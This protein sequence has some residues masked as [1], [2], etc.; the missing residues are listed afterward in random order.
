MPVGDCV[1]L[2][3]SVYSCVCVCMLTTCMPPESLPTFTTTH[4]HCH[5]RCHQSHTK[6]G[7]AFIYHATA[8]LSN[9]NKS[10]SLHALNIYA[11]L[12]DTT[13]VASHSLSHIT[14]AP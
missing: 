4:A 11:D 2:R 12:V 8:M 10:P 13:F 3:F 7:H 6:D 5:N 14:L 1:L 9:C